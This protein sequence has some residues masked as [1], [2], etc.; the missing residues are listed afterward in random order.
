[1]TPI[2]NSNQKLVIIEA[3]TRE[4]LLQEIDKLRIALSFPPVTPMATTNHEEKTTQT[5]RLCFVANNLADLHGK[6]DFYAKSQFFPAIT[7]PKK[8]VFVFGGLPTTLPKALSTIFSEFDIFR[9]TIED[10]QTAIIES[11][12][13]F[14]I[15][16][17]LQSP[18]NNETISIRDH[19]MPLLFAVQ[20]GIS[21]QLQAFGIYPDAIIGHS[22]GEYAGGCA[23]GIGK[24]EEVIAVVCGIA[25]HLQST[26]LKGRIYSILG[27]RDRLDK[28]LS[29][30]TDSAFISSINGDRS[31]LVAL[32]DREQARFESSIDSEGLTCEKL[33]IDYPFH[34]PLAKP[35]GAEIESLLKRAT[36]TTAKTPY[37]S[38]ALGR[39]ENTSVAHTGYWKTQLL[40]PARF[41]HCIQ[42]ANTSFSEPSFV[43]SG[44]G[45]ELSALIKLMRFHHR[46]LALP[47]VRKKVT[48]ELFTDSLSKIWEVYDTPSNFDKIVT[49]HVIYR[50]QGAEKRET[51]IHIPAL[52]KTKFSAQTVRQEY[53]I[54]EINRFVLSQIEAS[55]GRK[56]ELNSPTTSL[57]ID[58]LAV[59]NLI[60]SCLDQFRIDLAVEKVFRAKTVGD[61]GELIFSETRK[62]KKAKN[63]RQKNSIFIKKVEA[64]M[65]LDR[66]DSLT[67][68]E[69]DRYLQL[70]LSEWED[71]QA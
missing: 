43:D 55:A 26:P 30:F 44:P 40:E 48:A 60:T 11:G 27:P 53:S 46:P 41:A 68:P 57:G 67:E 50:K 10:C 2:S 42:H 69:V 64:E 23:A 59:L 37:I 51:K 12:Y 8:L 45:S 6:L 3:H 58:S 35:L 28:V 17:P 52:Q 33:W 18:N 62:M 14:D 9:Q 5:F 19:S 54:E 47:M 25:K 7:S 63:E 22:L 70:F 36:L 13:S 66:I 39:E 21:L 20:L 56:L 31:F 29:D 65:I 1:M 15:L 71:K 24:P 4:G 38:G 32:N 61:I 34:S 16:S 49:S